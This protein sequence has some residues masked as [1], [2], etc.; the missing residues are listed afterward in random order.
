MSKWIKNKEKLFEQFKEQKKQETEYQAAGPR[1]S[2]ITWKTPEKG[3]QE[4]PKNYQGRLLMDPN[5]NFYKTY[6]YHM[7]KGADSKW[8]FALCPK[9]YGMENYCPLCSAVSKLY[10]GNADDK[11]LAYQY[12]RKVKHVVNFYIIKDPRDVEVDNDEEVNAGKVLVYDCPTK[13]ESKIKNEMDGEY[14][15]GIKIFDPS[16][17]GYDFIVSVGAT[18]PQGD[19]KVWPD[20]SNSKFVHTGKPL[21]TDEEIDKIMEQRHSLDDYIKTM[22]RSAEDLLNI[23]KAEM[24][25]ELVE[26][27]YEGVKKPSPNVPKMETKEQMDD[28]PWNN[29]KKETETKDEPKTEDKSLSDDDLLKELED[30]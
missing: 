2:D 30:L 5:D 3:T 10:K 1:R 6:F 11:K 18:K 4:K 25:Y 28:V 19:G 8:V 17:E 14:A 15:A 24:L 27:D 7:F 16:K 9:T 20:Y 22:E 13:I 21:G 12:K 23:T 26:Q 29:D